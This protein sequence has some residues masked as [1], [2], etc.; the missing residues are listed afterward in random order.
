MQDDESEQCD[1]NCRHDKRA[2]DNPHL[3]RATPAPRRPAQD[4]TAA[5]T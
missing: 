1:N 4:S 3:D 2:A 5:A